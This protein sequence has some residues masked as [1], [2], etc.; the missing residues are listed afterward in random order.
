MNKSRGYKGKAASHKSHFYT[1]RLTVRGTGEHS[2]L[3]SC[4]GCKPTSALRAE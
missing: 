1:A 2:R 3:H 4:R